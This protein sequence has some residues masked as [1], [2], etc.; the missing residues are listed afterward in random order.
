MSII[1]KNDPRYSDQR[2]QDHSR[3]RIKVIDEPNAENQLE[4]LRQLKE[5]VETVAGERGP[6]RDRGVSVRD[7]EELDLI[8]VKDANGEI[9]IKYCRQKLKNNRS[10]WGL[11]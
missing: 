8:T 5:A 2:Q 7:L 9:Q 3:R 6:L 4:V 11:A 10:L 1:T